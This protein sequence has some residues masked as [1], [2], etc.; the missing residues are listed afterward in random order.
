MALAIF[1]IDKD[2]GVYMVVPPRVLTPLRDRQ[3]YTHHLP[4]SSRTDSEQRR[5]PFPEPNRVLLCR[6]TARQC[7]SSDV[8]SLV[9]I[10]REMYC[11]KR[12]L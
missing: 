4:I 2:E 10:S 7:G 1:S 12:S 8:E 11:L 9:G 3:L 5:A 6:A